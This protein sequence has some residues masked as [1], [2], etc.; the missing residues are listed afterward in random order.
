MFA[1]PP[2][3]TATSWVRALFATLAVG[4]FR[5]LRRKTIGRTE[6]AI[7]EA[8]A[9]MADDVE[10]QL[11]SIRLSRE[12]EGSDSEVFMSAAHHSGQ[13]YPASC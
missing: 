6:A 8:F 5:P 1:M 4:L 12:F 13:S 10:Y 9:R 11:D 3:L 2:D 7:D